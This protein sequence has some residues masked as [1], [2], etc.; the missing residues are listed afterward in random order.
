L[1][2]WSGLRPIG[3]HA[4]IHACCIGPLPIIHPEHGEQYPFAELQQEA[5]NT[6]S[7]GIIHA[8]SL[9]SAMG[10]S[11]SSTEGAC[12]AVGMYVR[13]KC[14]TY[15][16][17]FMCRC[18]A[19][20]LAIAAHP[21]ASSLDSAISTHVRAATCLRTVLVS[22]EHCVSPHIHCYLRSQEAELILQVQSTSMSEQ[23]CD[24]YPVTAAAILLKC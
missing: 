17:P 16:V 18:T 8:D 3:Q 13:C 22:H 5:T 11:V 15:V 1:Q 21:D 7:K 19:A 23:G 9:D 14:I 6:L 12:F 24:V 4:C 20:Q 2:V 10:V